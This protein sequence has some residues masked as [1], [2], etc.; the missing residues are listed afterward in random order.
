M[1][2]RR[3]GE[4]NKRERE[5]WVPRVE[6]RSAFH[7]HSV[8]EFQSSRS[9]GVVIA[10]AQSLSR[11]SLFPLRATTTLPSIE[12]PVVISCVISWP[13]APRVLKFTIHCACIV[14]I[15]LRRVAKEFANNQRSTDFLVHL[16]THSRRQ[17]QLYSSVKRVS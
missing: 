3:K 15:A 4:S 11:D 8:G 17:Q 9:V 6:W 14:L 2:E 10:H 12:S 16:S 5:N 1:M 7:R 13:T